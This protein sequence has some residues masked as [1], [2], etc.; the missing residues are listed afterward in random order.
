MPYQ[1][2]GSTS[3]PPATRING[4]H[5]DC[6]RKSDALL[7]FSV[8]NLGKVKRA[9]VQ[10]APLSILVG[11]NNTGKSYIAT[12]VWALASIDG[13]ISS[14]E[15]I[16]SWPK[17]FEEFVEPHMLETE[18][19]LDIDE[20]KSLEIVNY[21]NALFASTGSDYLSKIFAFKGFV[22]TSVKVAGDH[23]RPFRVRRSTVSHSTRATTEN[24]SIVT[25]TDEFGDTFMEYHFPIE[26]WESNKY[27]SNT[28]MVEIVNRVL[29]GDAYLSSLY[30]QL[31]IPAA[32][33][34]LMLALGSLVSEGLSP[35]DSGPNRELPQP[36]TAF[37][38]QMARPQ[39]DMDS[40]KARKLASWLNKNVAHGTIQAQ[41]T[42]GTRE[43]RY[44][45]LGSKVELPLHATSSMI[46]EL[47]PFLVSLEGG[48]HGR[49]II[50]EEPEAHLHL[51]AG[52]PPISPDKSAIETML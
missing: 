5:S 4:S 35:K 16:N 22:G 37:L 52:V 48:V 30:P 25:F 21:V 11:K 50:F 18:R 26:L 2:S 39:R 19:V 9:E 15:A 34:G 8:Q 38:R 36:L 45:P 20:A 31:Y 47:T 41:S 49:H 12:L 28:M 33:T 13:L 7:K 24:E 46:T 40:E 32:R 27:F 44:K 10:L 42:P 14:V 1:C 17:W 51:E 6:Y 43:F 23:Y 3:S 29:L